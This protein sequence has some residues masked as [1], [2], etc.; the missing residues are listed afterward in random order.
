MTTHNVFD[1]L[2]GYIKQPDGFPQLNGDK[3]LDNAQLPDILIRTQSPQVLT[4]AGAV[5]VTSII[6]HLITSGTGADALTLAD[7]QEGQEKIIL[8]KTLTAGGDTSVITPAHFANGTTITGNAVGSIQN[9]IFSNGA[10]HWTG[11]VDVVL[12]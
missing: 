1:R 7:G 9:L 10:W 6:T 5:D 4:G 11:G 12:A 3:K 2:R 8:I